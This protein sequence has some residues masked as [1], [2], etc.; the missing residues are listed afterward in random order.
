[1]L[2]LSNY[3]QNYIKLYNC[4]ARWSM[5]QISH[6]DLLQQLIWWLHRTALLIIWP[7]KQ[8]VFSDQLIPAWQCHKIGGY[9]KNFFALDLYS[10]LQDYFVHNCVDCLIYSC[11]THYIHNVGISFSRMYVPIVSI[12][13]THCVYQ[14]PLPYLFESLVKWF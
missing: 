6:I 11:Y 7:L 5:P 2:A 9:K 14:Y 3:H 8:A 10:T 12:W 13:Y 1:M 4:R